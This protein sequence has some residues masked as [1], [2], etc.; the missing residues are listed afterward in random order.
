[1][2]RYQVFL[3]S[4]FEDLVEERR[5]L[6]SALLNQSY[7][8]A[9]MEMFPSSPG[10][11]WPYIQETI[12]LSDYY[13]IVLRTSYGSLFPG[14][15]TSWTEREFDY[16]RALGKPILAF[17]HRVPDETF[18]ASMAA[19][20]KRVMDGQLIKY[21][22]DTPSLIGS[23][24]GSLAEAVRQ[25][26]APGWVRTDTFL[27]EEE[28]MLTYYRRSA[29]FDY[30]DLLRSAGEIRFLVNDGFSWLKRNLEAI[31]ERFLKIP[32]ART[33]VLHVGANS[34]MLSYIA[35]KSGKSLREQRR[36]IEQLRAR[37]REL[38]VET[39]YHNL[40]MFGHHAVNTHCLFINSDYAIVT[41][42]FT[43]N[44]RF[45]HLPLYKFRSGT[46]IYD[47]FKQDFDLLYRDA[48]ARE[49]DTA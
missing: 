10:A 35:K 22:N 48:S 9:G 33:I 43:S 2:K 31:R 21:W 44:N 5:L 19:F 18:D 23:V 7:L 1:M 3:S 28:S 30:G 40:E 27:D 29:E 34:P 15:T 6:G 16:A 4:P 41:T 45:L 32:S 14:E 39:N 26:P 38:A 20:R 25:Y 17:L 46:S 13:V 42:Y 47:D 36:D 11:T 49:A 8:P 37:L 24:L 12:K